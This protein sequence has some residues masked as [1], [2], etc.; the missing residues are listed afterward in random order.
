[1]SEDAH[2]ERV[3]KKLYEMSEAKIFR[4]NYFYRHSNV[5]LI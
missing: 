5:A 2:L 4:A 1:M 3:E